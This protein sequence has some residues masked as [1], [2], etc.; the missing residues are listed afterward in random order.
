[1]PLIPSVLRSV[2]FHLFLSEIGVPGSPDVIAATLCPRLYTM[3]MSLFSSTPQ[4]IYLIIVAPSL[5]QLYLQTAFPL[6]RVPLEDM[7]TNFGVLYPHSISQ[8]LGAGSEAMPEMISGTDPR[9][10]LVLA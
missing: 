8:Y 3:D 4:L 10:S 6:P 5:N 1:M 7:E 9:G 2:R